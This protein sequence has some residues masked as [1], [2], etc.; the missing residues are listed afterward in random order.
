VRLK[1]LVSIDLEP[2]WDDEDLSLADCLWGMAENYPSLGALV[3]DVA[4]ERI[5]TWVT[6]ERDGEELTRPWP[7]RPDD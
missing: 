6:L 3:A 7:Y 2:V 4:P 5:V 1:L